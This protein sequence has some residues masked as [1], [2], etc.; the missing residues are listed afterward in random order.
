MKQMTTASSPIRPLIAISPDLLERNGHETI[1]VTSSYAQRVWEAGGLGIVIPSVISTIPDLLARFDGF[2]FTGGDDPKTEPFDEPTHPKTTPVHPIRQEFETELLSAL[3]SDAPDHPVLG[4]CLGMQMMA[5]TSG[6]ALDQFMPETTP[7][8]AEHW[9]ANHAVLG[10]HGYPSGEVRSKHHQ[11]VRDAGSMR[12]VARAHD[13]IIEAID[14]PS[15]KHFV[16]VQWHPERTDDH[17][18]GQWYFD[19]LVEA[20]RR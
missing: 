8:H 4:V 1:R 12:V 2:V 15:R 10:E 3:R 5:L 19:Q 6:G 9:E 11:A 20:C 17:A 16:G 18:M 14:D 7:T 13:E